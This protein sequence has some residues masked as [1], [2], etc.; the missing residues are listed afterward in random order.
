[1]AEG[2]RV[3]PQRVQKAKAREPSHVVEAQRDDGNPV[4]EPPIVPGFEGDEVVGSHAAFQTPHHVADDTQ[5][6]RPTAE[7]AC[8]SS[9]EVLELSTARSRRIYENQAPG[10]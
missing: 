7:G 6:P 8:K 2:V 10:L 4:P 1:M 3:A 9:L 5:S